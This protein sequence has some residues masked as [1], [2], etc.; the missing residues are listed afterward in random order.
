MGGLRRRPAAVPPKAAPSKKAEPTLLSSQVALPPAAS[1]NGKRYYTL[2]ER[3]TVR[4][5]AIACGQDVAL[6][7]MGG[8]WL[9]HGQAPRGFLTWEEAATHVLE[10]DVEDAD[11]ILSICK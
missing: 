6:R 10:M 1:R 9:G 3:H 2:L 7:L 8:S 5:P 4:G 11:C